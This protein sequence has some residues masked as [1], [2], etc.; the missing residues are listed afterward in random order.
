MRPIDVDITRPRYVLARRGAAPL[1]ERA[2]HYSADEAGLAGAWAVVQDAAGTAGTD[3]FEV[4]EVSG[5]AAWAFPLDDE[6]P[7]YWESLHTD[8]EW[9]GD[10]APQVE[11]YRRGAMLLVVDDSGVGSPEL[12]GMVPEAV[13]CRPADPDNL[14]IAEDDPGWFL[15]ADHDLSWLEAAQQSQLAKQLAVLGAHAGWFL[16]ELLRPA[17]FDPYG[18]DLVLWLC[19]RVAAVA[20]GCVGVTGGVEPGC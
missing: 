19:D 2:L 18:E 17:G 5:D 1:T 6:R 16:V 7:R 11:V 14:G 10:V 13:G 8:D 9:L 12:V 15:M 4:V 20:A 3:S